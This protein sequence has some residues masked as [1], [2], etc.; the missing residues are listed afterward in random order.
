MTPG[1]GTGMSITSSASRALGTAGGSGSK[2]AHGTSERSLSPLE[3]TS[4]TYGL[5]LGPAPP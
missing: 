5:G 3:S 2:G 4:M 1:S